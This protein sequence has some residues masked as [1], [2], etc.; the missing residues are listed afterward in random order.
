MLSEFVF[1]CRTKKSFFLTSVFLLRR[2]Q[3]NLIGF[4]RN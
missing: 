2:Y 4:S 3:E 1:V